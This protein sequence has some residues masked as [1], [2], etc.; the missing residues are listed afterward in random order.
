VDIPDF[1]VE[2]IREG[3]YEDEFLNLLRKWNVIYRTA[4]CETGEKRQMQTF[5]LTIQ[6]KEP[7]Q[8]TK[9]LTHL[10]NKW[11]WFDFYLRCDNQESSTIRLEELV[12]LGARSVESVNQIKGVDPF[13]VRLT[14]ALSLDVLAT[15]CVPNHRDYLYFASFRYSYKKIRDK[16]VTLAT[17]HHLRFKEGAI[18]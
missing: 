13:H 18:E 7:G 10:F 4:A 11:F 14:G 17:Q 12:T 16:M 1:R 5:L 9:I 8:M 2:R 3:E 6:C 15:W